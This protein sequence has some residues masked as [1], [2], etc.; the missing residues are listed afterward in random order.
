M[1]SWTPIAAAEYLGVSRK[2]IYGLVQRRAIPH[3]RPAGRLLFDQRELRAWATGG[4]LGLATSPV[5]SNGV[6]R[7][8]PG[9]VG[10]A[11]GA[12]TRK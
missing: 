11:R 7:Q 9:A 12:S 2:A 5:Q 10:A 6:P 1:A 8:S 4:H 3:H